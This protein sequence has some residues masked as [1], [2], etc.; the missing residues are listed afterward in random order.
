MTCVLLLNQVVYGKKDLKV[1]FAQR[2]MGFSKYGSVM[3]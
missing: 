2:H 3:E 1:H